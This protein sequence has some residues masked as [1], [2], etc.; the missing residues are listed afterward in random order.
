MLPLS[1]KYLIE[2]F[3]GNNNKYWVLLG[4]QMIW[5]KGKFGC[6]TFIVSSMKDGKV[7]LLTQC[8]HEWQL[9]PTWK[10]YRED[11]SFKWLCASIHFHFSISIL[12][13]LTRS[14]INLGKTSRQ[15]QTSPLLSTPSLLLLDFYSFL[16]A[17]ISVAK[18]RRLFLSHK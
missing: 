6:C 4:W 16:I 7:H 5:W 12:F 2:S 8:I 10:N 3:F 11:G 18:E 1:N 15:H 14:R 17:S 9:N 13:G